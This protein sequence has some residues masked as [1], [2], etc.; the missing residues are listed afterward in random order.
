MNTQNIQTPQIADIPA[1]MGDLGKRARAASRQIGAASRE[2]KSRALQAIAQALDAARADLQAANALDL[3]AASTSGLDQPLVDRLLLDDRAI[4]RM[5]EG[6]RQVDGLADPVGEVSDMA[7]QANGLQ[8]GKMRVPLGVV[9]IIFESRPNVTADAASLC[10]KSGN[11]CILRGGSEAIH[12]NRAIG[13]CV[14]EG[15]VA[16]GLDADVVQLVQTTDRAAVG[17]LLQLAE[18]VDVIVPRGGY[19]LIERV[20]RESKIPVIKHLDGICHVYVDGSA[21]LTM[22]ADI[23]VNSK[24]EKYAVCNA[25]E[26]L[27][28]D[29]AVA[30]DLLPSLGERFAGAGVELRGCAQ[31]QALILVRPRPPKTI[32]MRVS[33]PYVGRARGRWSRRSDCAHQPLWFATHRHHCG[34]AITRA[35]G[36]LCSKSIP[37]R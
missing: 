11:A 14:S 37:P 1:Y 15:L 30:A 36:V 13:R 16:A 23:A 22:A 12:S 8:I 29:S 27:L 6:V 4:D 31:T 35:T 33:R 5:I 19:G 7:Y 17:A 24:T 20:N 32:G 10:L 26:T 34:A 25:I 2:Q 3:E 28:V 21:D 9:G 18:D